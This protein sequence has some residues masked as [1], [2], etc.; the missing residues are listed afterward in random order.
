M[1]IGNVEGENTKDHHSLTHV[2]LTP[3]QRRFAFSQRWVDTRVGLVV[4]I[5]T[6]TGITGWGDGYGPPWIHETIIKRSV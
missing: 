5:T 3:K 1:P 4:E 6:D 2:L